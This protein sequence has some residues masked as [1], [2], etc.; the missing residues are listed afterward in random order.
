M[1]RL[2]HHVDGRELNGSGRIGEDD[3]LGGTGEGGG[4][5]HAAGHLPLGQ[6]DVDVAW[7]DHHVD[8]ADALRSEGQRRDRL[9]STDGVDDVD[10]GNGRCR[11]R[12]LGDP[13]VGT[14]RHAD[15]HL[16]D[17]GHTG[18]N[19]R[20]ENGRRIRGPAPGDVTAGAFDGH[21]HRADHQPVPFPLVVRTDLARV[22]EANGCSGHL[23]CG[24]DRRLAR[25]KRCLHLGGPDH[26]RVGADAV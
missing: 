2:R 14:R 24:S 3:A 20:H 26:E 5:A 9:R 1:L 25:S 16:A 17:T 13:A 7:P 19:R 11:Q 6:G 18:R 8:R 15:H 12:H 21:H 23:E 10:P 4:N 22:V